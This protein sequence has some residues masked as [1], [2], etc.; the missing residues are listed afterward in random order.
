MLVLVSIFL[1]LFAWVS[2]RIFRALRVEITAARALLRKLFSPRGAYALR[3]PDGASIPVG[4]GAPQTR[5]DALLEEM[6]ER[7]TRYWEDRFPDQLVKFRIRC[8]AGKG[9]RSLRN[10]IGYLHATD[11]GLVFLTRRSFRFRSHRIDPAAVRDVRLSKGV[12]LDRVSWREGGAQ[13]T[14]LF[15]KNR[16]DHAQEV[17]AALTR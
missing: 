12:L 6:P 13:Q 4:M 3:T 7:H 9:V 1:V 10:S 14:F 5:R 2:P 11:S 15:F 16:A 8:A 17:V